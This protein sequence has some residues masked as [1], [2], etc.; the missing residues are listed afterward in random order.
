MLQ[1]PIEMLQLFL[2]PIVFEKRETVICENRCNEKKKSV[3]LSLSKGKRFP[4]IK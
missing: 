2:L 1:L 3:F 4:L